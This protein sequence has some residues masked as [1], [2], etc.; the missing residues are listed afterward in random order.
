MSSIMVARP[1]SFAD[2]SAALP[3]T[4]R[5]PRARGWFCSGS[6]FEA[7]APRDAV[8]GDDELAAFQSEDE[9]ALRGC[10]LGGDGATRSVWV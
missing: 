2:S 6:F 4:G 7:D 9:A 3:G 1:V 5:G 8:I 10:D